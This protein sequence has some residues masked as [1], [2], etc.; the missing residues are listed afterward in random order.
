LNSDGLGLSLLKI[1]FPRLRE[2]LDSGFIDSEISR[3]LCGS[4][5]D[6]IGHGPLM[7]VLERAVVHNRGPFSVGV[8]PVQA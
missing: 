6:A 5:D 8:R 7:P 4:C 1:R 3:D 2:D